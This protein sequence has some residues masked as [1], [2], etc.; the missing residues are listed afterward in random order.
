V[1]DTGFGGVLPVGEGILS[2]RSLEQAVGAIREVEGNYARHAK[3]ARA[4]AEEY[5]DS[6]KV[7]A[8]LL[9]E[10]VESDD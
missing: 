9:E 5:F 7:L 2:F 6:N 1:Q 10:T 4:I 3:A 8:R